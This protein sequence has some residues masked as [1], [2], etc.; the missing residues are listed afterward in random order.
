MILPREVLCVWNSS[1]THV[2]TICFLGCRDGNGGSQTLARGG[3]KHGQ[4]FVEIRATVIISAGTGK[5]LRME[6]LTLNSQDLHVSV[7]SNVDPSI[8]HNISLDQ[9]TAS[10]VQS[11]CYD[12]LAMVYKISPI[13]TECIS[14]QVR[15]YQ[16]VSP[17]AL[18]RVSVPI[19]DCLLSINKSSMTGEKR[20]PPQHHGHQNLLNK[21]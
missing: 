13:G 2:L 9:R 8:K 20:L 6:P 4:D 16:N 18:F 14:T 3:A 17:A 5:V 11:Y 19:I 21:P 15:M 7:T 10:Y 12:Y 1:L